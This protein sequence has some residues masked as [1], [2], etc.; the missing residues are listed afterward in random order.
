L[1]RQRPESAGTL[2]PTHLDA[3]R[4]ARVT[5]PSSVNRFKLSVGGQGRQ[6]FCF[7]GINQYKHRFSTEVPEL[8]AKSEQEF[9]VALCGSQ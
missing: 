3:N 7:E 9:S 6:P 2:F 1:T 8:S 5:P 4:Q